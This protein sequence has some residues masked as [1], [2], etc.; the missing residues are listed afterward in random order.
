M[1][2]SSDFELA[3]ARL[4]LRC[5]SAR[6]AEDLFSI[7]GDR[8]A[9][10]FWDWP[11]DRSIEET[12]KIALQI[13]DEMKAGKSLYMTARL[14]DGTFLGV[15]DLSEIDTPRADIGFMVSRRFWGCGYATEGTRALIAYAHHLPVR[16]L[17]ARI[18][19]ENTASRRLLQKV[20]FEAV[21]SPAPVEVRPRHVVTCEHFRLDFVTP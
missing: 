16:G 8:A 21:G 4:S 12:H 10:R 19:A 1:T 2:M 11:G 7:R 5:F 20:G 17:K 18:H 3:G 14:A 9:M 13:S 6:D 15:F